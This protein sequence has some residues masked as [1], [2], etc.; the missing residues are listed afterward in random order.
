MLLD[1]HEIVR[2]GLTAI[3]ASAFEVCGAV[4]SV[5]EALAVG[6][7]LDLVLLDIR[8]RDQSGLDAIAGLR[9][10]FAGARIVVLT[11]Y[12][13]PVLARRAVQAGAAGFLI[14]DAE[15]LDL[16][17]SLQTVLGGGTVVDP[18]LAGEALA[19]PAPSISARERQVLEL[20]SIGLSNRQ[21]ASEC[22]LSEHTVKE[23]V[24]NILA[25][26]GC[27]TRAEAVRRGAELHLIETG[28]GTLA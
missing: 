2:E 17:K 4:G 24:S 16:V 3:L 11:A 25:K 19:G 18:R 1:D 27:R 10:R 28:S 20:V 23:H 14:K 6:G 5:E 26:L 9:A 7:P 8:L 13:D 22:H 12:E 21:I 15:R